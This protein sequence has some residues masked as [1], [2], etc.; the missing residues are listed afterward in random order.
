MLM[1]IRMFGTHDGIETVQTC[2]FQGA[3]GTMTK[4]HYYLHAIGNFAQL[5]IH[6]NKPKANRFATTSGD[7]P[8]QASRAIRT[9]SFLRHHSRSHFCVGPI[10]GKWDPISAVSRTG[11]SPLAWTHFLFSGSSSNKD[12][13]KTKENSLYSSGIETRLFHFFFGCFFSFLI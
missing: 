9:L 12:L 13:E 5:S 4:T 3:L 10:P 7:G 6:Y 2:E 1:K 11:L 8:L